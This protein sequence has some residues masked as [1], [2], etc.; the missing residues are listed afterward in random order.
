MAL[1]IGGF[2]AA[3]A[4]VGGLV[5]YSG[6]KFFESSP[7]TAHV[8]TI[9]KNEIAAHVE[10]DNSHETFQ[11][12]IITILIGAVAFAFVL[13]IL[14]YAIIGIKAVRRNNNNNNNND[15]NMHAI[16]IDV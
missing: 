2:L 9:V 6:V 8:Q 14:R 10:A 11:N 7:S 16:N 3:A 12:N 5:T 1:I 15:H 13:G 4:A